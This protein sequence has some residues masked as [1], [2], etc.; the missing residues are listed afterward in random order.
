MNQSYR[1]WTKLILIMLGAFLVLF[2]NAEPYST[3]FN[4][5]VQDARSGRLSE[6]DLNQLV[7]YLYTHQ[8]DVLREIKYN[9][10]A[11]YNYVNETRATTNTAHKE[12]R[13]SLTEPASTQNNGDFGFK[14]LVIGDVGGSAAVDYV[15][16]S[17][18]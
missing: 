18:R 10:N 8:I 13:F 1:N 17:P 7:G 2:L 6:N 3:D 14:T 16:T 4:T 15:V 12:V 5:L 11:Y 9:P